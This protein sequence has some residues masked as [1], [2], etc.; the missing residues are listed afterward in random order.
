[1]QKH[2][3]KYVL[4]QVIG[5][6]Q[7][8]GVCALCCPGGVSYPCSAWSNGAQSTAWPRRTLGKKADTVNQLLMIKNRTFMLLPNASF[9]ITFTEKNPAVTLPKIIYHHA[10]KTLK[11]FVD[12]L[13]STK[14]C[15]AIK[16]C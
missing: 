10:F 8:V 4:D 7:C 14:Q 6:E 9:D 1:M 3:L 16:L 12:I 5:F 11:I 13:M 15:S 2:V